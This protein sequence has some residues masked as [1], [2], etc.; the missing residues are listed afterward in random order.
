MIIVIPYNGRLNYLKITLATLKEAL[1]GHSMPPVLLYNTSE[2]S[3]GSDLEIFKEFSN[4][5]ILTHIKY[6]STENRLFIDK[7]IPSIINDVL[8]NN[9]CS[10]VILL[11]SD[12]VVHPLAIEKFKN[13]ILLHRDLGIGSLFNTESHP[14]SGL[15]SE[16]LG[17]KEVM[18][19]FGWI[20]SKRAWNTYCKD[21]KSNWDVSATNNITKSGEFKN[22]CTINSYLEHI[23]FTGTHKNEKKLGHPLSIDRALN[24][25]N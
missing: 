11:D 13:L 18:G 24:L 7:L 25:F 12:T 9:I 14:F 4:I 3:E 17:I 1:R 20:I 10:Y 21:I 22:Y 5:K 19:G 8:S 6:P 15:V 2:N 23:G 16:N